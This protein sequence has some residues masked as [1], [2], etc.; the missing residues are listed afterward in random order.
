MN[1][2][3]L[4]FLIVLAYL[5]VFFPIQTA[6]ADQGVALTW[7]NKAGYWFACGPI[8]C[9]YAGEKSEEKA[10]NY[11]LSDYSHSS[12]YK[13]KYGRC[14]QYIVSGVKSYEYSVSKVERLAKC[15]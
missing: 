6:Q 7:Q 5:V 14:N 2:M 9:I 4:K 15:D 3:N 10:L 12:A 11:V 13:N 8:Q 1:K